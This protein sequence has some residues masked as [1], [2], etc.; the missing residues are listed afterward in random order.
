MKRRRRAGAAGQVAACDVWLDTAEL[1]RSAAQVG[2][3]PGSRVAPGGVRVRVWVRVSVSWRSADENDKENFRP[4]PFIPNKD[5][6]EKGVSLA[7]SPV[8]VL[9]LPQ[10][11]EAQN[12]PFGAEDTVL[13]AAQPLPLSPESC[14]T[15]EASC[16][17]GGHRCSFSFTQDSEGNRIIAHRNQSSPSAGGTVSARNQKKKPQQSSHV[18]SLIDFTAAENINPALRRDSAWARGFPSSPQRPPGAQPLRE[19]SHNSGSAMGRGSRAGWSSPDLQLF[20]QDSEG[21]RV[22]AHCCWDIPSPHGDEGGSGKQPPPAPCEGCASGAVSRSWG[23]GREQQV[24][25]GWEL[26]FT[27]DSEGNRVI[28]HW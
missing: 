3:G 5:C 4:S 20:T 21:N 15:G 12:G 10:M 8:K 6:K 22:I 17:A 26:L 18:N 16:G 24:E 13:V 23:D 28:K 27:Q 19:R 2:P 1:K 25:G 7:A 11:E 14:S 9:A